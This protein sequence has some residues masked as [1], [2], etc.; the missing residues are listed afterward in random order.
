MSINA[1][2]LGCFL[3]LPLLLTSP[4]SSIADESEQGWIY[5]ARPGDN[6]WDITTRYLTGIKY[7][8]P[9]QRLN[10]I[11]RPRHIPPG[12]HIH[13]P[14]KWSK[15]KL[16]GV[17]IKAVH[18]PVKLKKAGTGTESPA[19]VGQRLSQQDI[20]ITP[21]NA[22]VLLVFADGSELLLVPESSLKLEI[23]KAYGDGDVTDSQV[24][25]HQGQAENRNNPAK[26]P[27]TRFKIT[28]PS[29]V[30]A[31][32]GTDFRV[33][34]SDSVS[35]IEV[36][37]G[38]VDVMGNS[39]KHRLTGGYGMV[40]E[41]HQPLKEPIVLLPAPDL[42]SVPAKIET[43]YIKI[44]LPAM[45]GAVSYK[46]QILASNQPDLLLHNHDYA[47][48]QVTANLAGLPDDN[49]ILRVRA[50]DENG[51]EGNDAVTPFELNAYPAAPVSITPA[52]GASIA[53]KRPSFSWAQP[54]GSSGYQLQVTADRQD[55]TSI[56]SK[57][58]I[59]HEQYTLNARLPAGEYHWRVQAYDR[60]GEPGP[61]GH[62]QSFRVL[63]GPP[64][65][66]EP[67]V[68]DKG[69][70]LQWQADGPNQS[71]HLQL[72]RD[73]TF[74]D[75]LVDD[76]IDTPRYLLSSPRQGD[77]FMRVSSIDAEGYEGPYST[78]QRFQVP[79]PDRGWVPILMFLAPLIIFL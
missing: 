15:V 33:D 56:I 14:V 20:I 17:E 46:V 69:L 66:K 76:V 48:K 53:G 41:S 43:P 75:L 50:I 61:F 42:A 23:L 34:S 12:T 7:W 71:Y 49:Y 67:S 55:K 78:A 52:A 65:M 57:I 54:E 47:P 60:Q 37:K 77:Y 11:T 32:R 39:S 26:I 1:H 22:S 29:A 58:D 8:R 63:P 16:A 59:E 62:Y 51:L 44:K 38:T 79:G 25:L 68:N 35:R 6:L 28:T 73:E 72:S 31:I 45:A 5:V 2:L 10:N 30:M 70:A 24:H 13:I 3:L 21:D 9:L 36:L 4:V 40:V 18:G 74:S 64:A 27:G 19:A